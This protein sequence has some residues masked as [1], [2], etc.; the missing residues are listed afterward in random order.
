MSP[1]LPGVGRL[2]GQNHDADKPDGSD[3]ADD[4]NYTHDT[5]DTD[6]T[7]ADRDSH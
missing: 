3:N 5:D 2:Q 7:G 1:G 4:T 6:H